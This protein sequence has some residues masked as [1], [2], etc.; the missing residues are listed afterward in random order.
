MILFKNII[1]R[2]LSSNPLILGIETSCDDTGVAIL[3]GKQLVSECLSTQMKV[4]LH[5]GGILPPLAQDFHRQNIDKTVKT[6]IERAGID[7]KELDA[8]AFTNRPGLPLSLIVGTRYARY[9]SRKYNK[10]LIPIHHMHAHA[11]TPRMER[12][13]VKFPFLCLLISGGHSLLSYVKDINDFILLG[14]SLD[15]AP[16]EC[17]DKIARMMKL[18]NL[19]Q[20]QNVSGG[21]AIEEAARM[22]KEPTDKYYFPLM[23]KFYRD[24]QFS[25]AGFKNVTNKHLR[26][27]RKKLN[28]PV[29]QVIPDYP[30]FCANLQGAVARHLCY[31]TQRAIEFCEDQ[32]MFDNVEQRTLVVSGGVA[33][34]DFIFEALKQMCETKNFTAVRPSRKLCMDNGIMI[35]WN[36]VEKFNR[37][38]DICPPE[39]I[40]DLDFYAKCPIGESYIDKVKEKNLSCKWIKTPI[41]K[42]FRRQ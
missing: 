27:E 12:D 17:L 42:P 3:K 16:G 37:N 28:L 9:M 4:H 38:L 40:Y 15:D 23:L 36:G 31:R 14:Q 13:D 41:L 29:D 8:I 24:C 34:N 6:C 2:N 11:L 32:H 35:A 5:L 20:F 18:I 39:K 7:P 19:K 30:D 1:R 33:C 25:F 22:C 26:R 21:Q 10:P